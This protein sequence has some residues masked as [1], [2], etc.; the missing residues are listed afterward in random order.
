M[1]VAVVPVAA[2]AGWLALH[3]LLGLPS[4]NLPQGEFAVLGARIDTPTDTS[5][6]AIYVLV[7]GSPPRY[8]VL[9]YSKHAAEQLQAALN[10]GNGIRMEAQ[11]G[12]DVEFGEAPVAADEPKQAETPIIGG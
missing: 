1:S 4:H 2:L 9:P 8:Y 7:D 5:A 6:G 3:A 11:E 10:D 12:G